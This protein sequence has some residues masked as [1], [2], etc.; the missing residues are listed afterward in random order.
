MKQKFI[1]SKEI[2]Y[3][4]RLKVRTHEKVILTGALSM[5]LAMT[6]GFASTAVLVHIN[7]YSG[8]GGGLGDSL[9]EGDFAVDEY[10]QP[11]PGEEIAEEDITGLPV[12]SNIDENSELAALNA[13]GDSVEPLETDLE[14]AGDSELAAEIS[15]D[16]IE[17]AAQ[18]EKFV[19][20]PLFYRVYRVKEND[21]VGVIAKQFGV[22]NGTIFSANEGV[23]SSALSLRVNSLLKIP[24]MKGVLYTVQKDGE[25]LE[26]I[27]KKNDVNVEPT[28]TANNR[29]ATEKLRSG[30]TV[31]LVD[32]KMDPGKLLELSGELFKK[33]LHSAY[34]ISS[35]YGW[36]VSPFDSSK[37][38]YHGGTDLACPKGTSIFPTSEGR[39]ITAGWSSIYGNY[40]IVQHHSGYKSLYGHMSK[41][42]CEKGNYVYTNTV[43]G[44]VGSTGMSTGP[45]LH[46]TIY[47]NGKAINP[48][49]KL[50]L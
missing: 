1:F 13:I 2:C 45:H 38:T 16:L 3:T 33:P 26:T 20:T 21:T 12:D 43:I 18:D 36:R 9:A 25:T 10:N 34:Y 23:I 28:V 5:F 27:C 24:S 42:T 46:F 30:T 8:Q 40:V 15:H 49:D 29:T 17:D 14:L 4:K 32:G 41:I 35:R 31:F 44:K 6:L 39:V 50:N 7:N 11:L 47:K 37:R 22:D 19:E 48:E